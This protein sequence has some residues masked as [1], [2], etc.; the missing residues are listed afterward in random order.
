MIT[1]NEISSATG[2]LAEAT[3]FLA[4]LLDRNRLIPGTTPDND[5]A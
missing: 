3:G 1:D 5:P 4:G 2:F